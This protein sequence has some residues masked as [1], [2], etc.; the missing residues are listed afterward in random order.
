MVLL[1]CRKKDRKEKRESEREREP[2]QGC[3]E[4]RQRKKAEKAIEREAY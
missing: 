1:C 2:G 4:E 3:A